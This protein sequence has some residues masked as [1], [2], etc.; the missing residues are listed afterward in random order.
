MTTRMLIDATHSEE[1]RVVVVKG[2]RLEEFDYESSTKKQ[3]KGN[4]Y[5]AKVT[6]VEPALQA[7]FVDYGGN[8]HGFLAFSEIHPD[9]YQI[10]VEDR[11]ALLDE[12][13]AEEE[14]ESTAR[15]AAASASEPAIEE[16]LAEAHSDGEEGLDQ[17]GDH[18]DDNHDND[19]GIEVAQPSDGTVET[20]GAEDDLEEVTN[21]RAR[22]PRRYKIQE[23]IRRRQILL[24]QVVKEER[25]N[26]G[27]ALT[28]YLSLAG[29]F[30]VLMPNTARGGGISR[31]I[32]N[33]KD[34]KRLK[35]IIDG[36]ELPEGMGV[37]VRTA[38]MEQ[39]KREIKRDY[40][41][42][43]RLWDT[44]REQTLNS[45]APALIHEEGNL[46]KRSIRD[47][48]SKDIDE[49][50]VE[51]DE[52]YRTA[53]EFMRM[54]MPSHAKVVQPYKENIPLF[55][56]YQVEG[57]LDS[58]FSPTVH[59][60]SGGYIVINSTEALVAVDVNSGRATREHNIEETALKTNTEAAEE[61]ARQL[62]LRDLA[63]LIVIDFIDMERHQNNRSVERR[64][65]DRLKFDRARIQVGRIS[66]FGLLEMS[67]QRLRPG[68]L[69]ATTSVCNHC[70]GTGIVRSTES[71]ALQ[72]IRAIEEEGIRGRSGAV[73][74]HAPPVVM[75]YIL[76]QKRPAINDVSLRYNMT[77][78]ILSDDELIAPNYTIDRTNR[79]SGE[80][81]AVEAPV[82][83]K[84][85]PSRPAPEVQDD[86]SEEG[87]KSR[88]R[89][90]GRRRRGRAGE[91]GAEDTVQAG[92]ETEEAE[93]PSAEESDEPATDKEAASGDAE[94]EDQAKPKSRR[95]RGRRG[96]RSRRRDGDKAATAEQEGEASEAVA[97]V[98]D[99]STEPHPLHSDM[100]ASDSEVS[101]S[102]ELEPAETAGE[103]PATPVAEP[104]PF[105]EP[106]PVVSE[107][108]LAASDPEP[109]LETTA[110]V[111]AA[112]ESDE[113]ESSRPR[114]MGWWQRRTSK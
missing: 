102:A 47:L 2:N 63:G 61:V 54:L 104:E 11:Q 71:S 51:G 21:R 15:K 97:E 70:A 69:E 4:I 18:A 66:A 36:L 75:S 25:G 64:L 88:R 32:A 87:R 43:I 114:R 19:D 83:E 52:G 31:K 8:R 57:Q 95:R 39:N 106:E 111:S 20:V 55:S 22:R 91:E 96:G 5:L 98:A 107:P 26:K 12:E 24:V 49:V 82:E 50:L 42:L 89:R 113:D 46:I 85:A 86:D 45:S 68:L 10:P 92:S 73:T 13:A 3:L 28:S 90:R 17:T 34:R 93:T 56:R 72:V 112:S 78:Q 23:V 60:K 74:V 14:E 41:Y 37:I 33:A 76:N 81:E 67:R 65:K 59:L 94:G 29:R 35:T 77:I 99:A 105:I 108:A 62:R 30:C 110:E 84:A 103:E 6:R 40:D 109:E 16:E 100:A 53:K 101:E 27:A 1:T 48:Y 44:I 9:Y 38:G 7:A 79:P 80:V 58:M